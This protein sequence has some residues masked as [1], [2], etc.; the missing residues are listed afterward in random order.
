MKSWLHGSDIEIYSACDDVK[1]V[2]AETFIRTLKSK[3]YN[4][5]TAVS[6]YMCIDTLDKLVGKYNNTYLIKV[7]SE[8]A[9][10]VTYIDFGIEPNGKNPNFRVGD[11][12]RISKHKN[13][14]AKGYTPYWCE[15]VFAIR[16]LKNT[17]SWTYA[18]SDLH[19]EE[20]VVTFFQKWLQERR[21]GEF[22]IEKII[23][24][25]GD[26]LYVKWKSYNSSFSSLINT[27]DIV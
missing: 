4:H 13:I 15:E 3:I 21:Q 6:K 1:Y 25:K 12:A 2:V 9:Y 26:R 7:K 19:D 24:K 14:L 17:V 23:K 11:H 8:N 20:V 10:M 22:R 16:K 18:N 5:M 27:E